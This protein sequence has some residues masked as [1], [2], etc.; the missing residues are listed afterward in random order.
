MQVIFGLILFIYY[1][2][3]VVNGF[4]DGAPPDACGDM[5]DIVPN[6]NSSSPSNNDIPYLVDLSEF[7]HYNR[8][9]NGAYTPGIDY[10]CKCYNNYYPANYNYVSDGL[11]VRLQSY[12]DS[13]Y[14]FRGFMIQARRV[15]DNSTAGYFMIN[16]TDY[17][18]QCDNGVSTCTHICS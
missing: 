6:H 12:L 15:A 8:T 14:T 1:L 7:D 3:I 10:Y 5:T 17:Q 16:G 2:M 13:N 18:L 11:T 9:Y 4:P